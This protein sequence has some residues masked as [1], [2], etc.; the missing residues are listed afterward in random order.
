MSKR[1]YPISDEILDILRDV[2]PNH[3]KDFF[4]VTLGEDIDGKKVGSLMLDI[5]AKEPRI[6]DFNC[7]SAE[8]YEA[9]PLNL[10]WRVTD[11]LDDPSNEGEYQPIV[12]DLATGLIGIE[13]NNLSFSEFTCFIPILNMSP[14]IRHIGWETMMDDMMVAQ[15]ERPV[16]TVDKVVYADNNDEHLDHYHVIL[17]DELFGI[18]T[19]DLSEQTM[20]IRYVNKPMFNGDADPIPEEPVKEDHQIIEAAYNHWLMCNAAFA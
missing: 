20:V 19:H 17:N 13:D 11:P 5:V 12:H 7:V 1:A 8:P 4:R 2:T 14:A 15:Q 6:Y 10:W 16:I 3:L 18:V 9:V